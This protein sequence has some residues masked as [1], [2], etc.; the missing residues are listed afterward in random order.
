MKLNGL[1]LG[2]AAL[3]AFFAASC[4]TENSIPARAR[5]KPAAYAATKIWEKRFVDDGVVA[6]GFTPD[7]V[8]I[9][10]GRPTKVETQEFPQGKAELWT[11]SRCYPTERALDSYRRNAGLFAISAAYA[12]RSPTRHVALDESRHASPDQVAPALPDTLVRGTRPPSL[13]K[14]GGTQAGT[15]DPGEIPSFTVMI[16]FEGGKVA[17]IGAAPN[18]E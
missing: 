4:A 13:A 1:L 12:P 11:Y 18:S 6:K 10:L 9:A 3:L 2:A 17:R 15:M 5:E 8:Y 14:T 7:L 16:L